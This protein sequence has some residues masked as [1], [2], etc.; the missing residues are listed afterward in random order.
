MPL[1][2]WVRTHLIALGVVVAVAV[3]MALVGAFGTMGL[4]PF[5]A[6][7]AYWVVTILPGYLIFMPIIEGARWASRAFDLPYGFFLLPGIFIGCVPMTF[8][9]LFVIDW[10]GGPAVPFILLY[11]N[12]TIVSLLIAGIFWWRAR[13]DGVDAVRQAATAVTRAQAGRVAADTGGADAAS[14]MTEE[15]DPPLL[16]RLPAGFGPILAL[17]SE[18]HYV[19]VHGAGR[20]EMLLMRLADAMREAAPTPG[21]QVHRSWWVAKSAVENGIQSGRTAT[22]HLSNGL[23]VP[24]SRANLAAARDAG[25][26]G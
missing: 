3:L 23:G 12:V 22:L 24:V 10:G 6:R 11:Q 26:L 8:V 25:L 1:R 4:G 19:R 9:V 15:P 20:S 5:P 13:S 17:Q 16:A 14:S 7:L 21:L 2:D 18:D